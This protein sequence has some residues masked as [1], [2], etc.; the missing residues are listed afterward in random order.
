MFTKLMALI[1]RL[2]DNLKLDPV[3]NLF[4]SRSAPEP[5]LDPNLPEKQH[6]NMHPNKLVWIHNSCSRLLWYFL[7]NREVKIPTA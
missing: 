3:P 2:S 1:L 5:G 7:D 6:P 4:G